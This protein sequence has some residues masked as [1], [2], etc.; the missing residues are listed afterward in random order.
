MKYAYPKFSSKLSNPF[1]A[2]AAPGLGNCLFP[3]ARAIAFA[4]ENN[5]LL[6]TPEWFQLNIGPM[7][8]GTKSR[9][10]A[11]DFRPL[12]ADASGIY[13]VQALLKYP[14]YCEY[15]WA[16]R[17]NY[18]L[19]DQNCVVEFSGMKDWFR[20]I[21]QTRKV[22]TEEVRMRLART[23]EKYDGYLGVHVRLGD[24]KVA[25]REELHA[26]ARNVRAPFSWYIDVIK[27]CLREGSHK[28]VVY[29]TDAKEAALSELLEACPGEISG[30]QG[31]INDM[32]SLASAETIVGT[33]ST[34]ALWAYF[35]SDAKLCLPLGHFQEASWLPEGRAIEY[36][37]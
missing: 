13:K 4:H 11:G 9:N 37:R 28:G 8:R 35:F 10:C 26:G 2:I 23:Y 7:L 17:R 1:C 31:P 5:A 24:F 19:G 30:F 34:F 16:Y 15:E 21:N 14:R 22:I 33:R 18:T 6:I 27:Q 25:T 32:F 12:S 20:S 36:Y 3:L 29:F